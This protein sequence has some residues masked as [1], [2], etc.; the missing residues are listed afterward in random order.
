MSARLG[1]ALLVSM[2]EASM[3]LRDL[4]ANATRVWLNIGANVDPLRPPDDKSVIVI[5]FEP[6]VHTLIPPAARRFVVPA[7]VSNET[8]LTT[9]I[10]YNDGLS[11]SLGVPSKQRPW[12]DGSQGSMPLQTLVVPVVTMEGVLVA[13]RSSLAIWYL[14][15][16]VQGYDATILRAAGPA[17]S[18]I[19]YIQSEVWLQGAYSYS[20]A[21]NDYCL[22]V[23][24]LMRSR[25]FEPTALSAAGGSEQYLALYSNRS[26]ADV[27]HNRCARTARAWN[28]GAHPDALP[29]AGFCVLR[30][31]QV[32]LYGRRR[33]GAGV[34]RL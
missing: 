2:A 25:G 8:G 1:A 30:P 13:I 20:G 32:F 4:P 27:K 11:A 14:K 34:L 33:F 17:L 31:P 19:Q 12:N 15:S 28:F 24:P 6:V 29:T 10:S 22:D 18:R 16:D 5:A 9:M 26:L 23:L 7:A 21:N 3:E